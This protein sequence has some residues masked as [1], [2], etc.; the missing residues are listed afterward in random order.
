MTLVCVIALNLSPKSKVD[1]ITHVVDFN[2][3]TRVLISG[4]TTQFFKGLTKL[5]IFPDYKRPEL[6]YLTL[7]TRQKFGLILVI[8]WL[9]K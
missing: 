1:Q 6:I 4:A 3:S 9:K 2:L 5:A 8:M 7:P